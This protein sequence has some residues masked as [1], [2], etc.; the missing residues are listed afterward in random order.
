MTDLFFCFL[1]ELRLIVFYP[2]HIYT[3]N[4]LTYN[5]HWHWV[6]EDLKA[7]NDA[8]SH[9]HQVIIDRFQQVRDMYR[10]LIKWLASDSL[11]IFSNYNYEFE[12]E[13]LCKPQCHKTYAFPELLA[14]AKQLDSLKIFPLSD[15]L[16][17]PGH[18]DFL[19]EFLTT[20]EE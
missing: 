8:Y 13:V 16:N 5:H 18:P 1:I 20:T 2:T 6:V 11:L 17:G 7:E 3:L 12:T 19:L 4:F 14:L 15:L 10:P 9:S